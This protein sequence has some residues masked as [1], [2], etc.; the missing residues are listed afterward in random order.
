MQRLRLMEAVEK[1][2]VQLLALAMSTPSST[3][4]VSKVQAVAVLHAAQ[5]DCIRH[6][7]LPFV[8]AYLDSLMLK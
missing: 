1:S 8:W 5:P 4:F 2:R 7:P 6:E 3:F